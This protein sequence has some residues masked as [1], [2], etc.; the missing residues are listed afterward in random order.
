MIAGAA[1]DTGNLGVSALSRSVVTEL[2]LRLSGA[3]ITVLDHT[4]GCGV[5]DLGGIEK[6]TEL[7]RAGA[8]RSRRLWR[9]ESWPRIRAEARLPVVVSASAREIVSADVILDISG[10]DS[11]TDLYGLDRFR[12]TSEPKR[13]ALDR[14]IPLILLPQTYGPYESPAVRAE[15]ALYLRSALASWARDPESYERMQGLL[16][17]DFDPG[18]HRESVDVAFLLEPLEPDLDLGEAGGWLREEDRSSPVAG[19]NVSGLIYND[20]AAMRSQYRFKADYREVVLRLVRRLLD[21]TDAR[22]VLVPHVLVAPDRIE[23]DR[24]ACLAV[25]GELDETA[26]GRVAVLP[27]GLDECG[28]KWC[29]SR[30]D[31]FC[32]MWMHSTIAG[33]STRTPTAAIAYSLKTRGVFDTCG[34]ADAVADPREHDTAPVVEALWASYQGR[35]EQGHVLA[36][37]VP[38]VRARASGAFDEIASLCRRSAGIGA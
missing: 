31:W 5:L 32:G 19:V 24:R 7:R 36:A 20:P 22:V 21:E 3:R 10:G 27:D 35:V 15:A 9:G 23:S 1:M 37:R 30:C 26:P 16:G 2:A 33:L 34:V 14:G 13:F 28:A 8:V 17:D 4:R 12:T 29:I 11:F 25:L 6:T 18:R 38:G